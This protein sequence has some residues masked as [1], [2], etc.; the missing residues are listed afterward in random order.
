MD[1]CQVV[2]ECV[3]NQVKS[4]ISQGSLLKVLVLVSNPFVSQRQRGSTN[5]EGGGGEHLE[6]GF[7]WLPSS[8]EDSVDV[9]KALD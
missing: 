9:I 2:C 4:S 3:R 8:Q 6:T 7:W 1:L 5:G